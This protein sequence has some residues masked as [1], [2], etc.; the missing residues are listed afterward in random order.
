MFGL[1]SALFAVL[2]GFSTGAMAQG[3]EGP[4]PDTRITLTRDV[5]LPG[6]DLRSIFDTTLEACQA[7]CLTDSAC[8][9]FTFNSRSNSCFPKSAANDTEP[10]VGAISG[11]VIATDPAVLAQASTR[12]A[13]LSFV[14][15]QDIEK[16]V[17]LA[18][19]LGRTAIADTAGVEDL[20]QSAQ[21]KRAGGWRDLALADVAAAISLSDSP[22]LWAY[23]AEIALQ[24]AVEGTYSDRENF[25]IAQLA[26]VNAYLRST[27][28]QTRAAF[29]GGLASAFEQ[30]G[31]GRMMIP[32]LRLATDLS[33]REDLAAE[34]TRAIGQYGFRVI[35]TQV[36]SNA[37]EPRI[38]AVFSEA[39]RPAGTD[40]ARFVRTQANGLAISADGTQLCLNG[41][42]HGERYEFT[43]RAGLPGTSGEVLIKDVTLTQYVRD[44]DP[45][46]RF[47]GRA[48]VL[49]ATGSPSVPIVTVNTD[50]VNLTLR[51]V[52]ER[53]LVRAVQDQYFGR[54]LSPW[55]QDDFASSLAEEVWTGTGEVANT[56]N[57]E[58][59]T[60]LPLDQALGDLSAGIY[61][62]QASVPDSNPYDVASAS[63]WFVISDLGFSTLQGND[64]L[65]V[66]A[67]SLRDTTP[68][69]GV[70]VTLLSRSNRVL[71]T[72]VTDA[73]G[74]LNLQPGLLAGTG[75]AE[76][77]LVVL[78][79]GD[80]DISFMS[81]TDPA[82]DL[83]DRGVTGRAPPE[84]IDVFL[85]T[86]RGAYRAGETIYATALA[87]DPS[88]VA[89]TDVPLTAILRRPDGVEYARMRSDGAALGGH[90][91]DFD[92]LGG[93]PRGTWSVGVYADPDRPAL[94]R[95]T[96]LV[97]DFLPERFDFDLT[98]ANGAVTVQADYLFGAPAAELPVE[99]D[100]T[101]TGT[102]NIDAYPGYQFGAY[103]AEVP[104]GSAYF[105]D[106]DQTDA[107]GQAVIDA[108]LPDVD[109][110]GWPATVNITMR[111]R[112]GSGR[113]VE[114]R[115]S[116]AADTKGTKI[117]IKPLFDD[118]LPEGDE[119]RFEIVTLGQGDVPVARQVEWE[120]N[121][122]QTRYQWYQL[123][124]NWNWE[125]VTTRTRI[126]SGTATT[127]DGRMSVSE[128]VAWGEYELIVA[129]TGGNYTRS[130]VSFY[131]GWYGGGAAGDSPDRLEMSLDRDGYAI[132]D[133]AML[134]VVPR[135]A[136][137]A[138]ITVMDDH[139]I[140]RE[141]VQMAAGENRIPLQI[142]ADWGAGA[143]VGVTLFRG[144]DV[145]N[146][147]EPARAMGIAY[148]PISPA[149]R[150][151]D[152]TVATVGEVSPRAP[153]TATVTIANLPANEPAYVT[154]A[155]VDVGILNLTGFETPEP[156]A[157]FFGQRKLGLGIRDVYGRLI[158]TFGGAAGSIRSGG[159]AS[160]QMRLQSPPPTEDL[161]AYFSGPLPVGADGTV[162]ATFDI[163]AFN[164]TVRLMAMAWSVDG[165][166]HATTDVIIAD[167]VVMTASVPRFMAPGDET[168][169]LLDLQRT[170]ALGGD[171]AFAMTTSDGLTITNPLP[172]TVAL[173]QT[174]A[175]NLRIPLRAGE[176]GTQ[177]VNLSLTL[178][179]GT[180]LTK[181][182]TIPVMRNDP[183]TLRTNRFEVVSGA[184]FTLTQ[185]VFDGFAPGTARATLAFGPL[186][187]FDAPGLLQGL[188]R[189]PYGCTEQI[190]ARALP[191]LYFN[192]V[193]DAMG[194]GGADELGERLNTAVAQ[195][196]TN[197]A[198]NGSFGLWSA[199]TGDLWLD[200]YVTDFLGRA[201]ANGLTVP[202]LAYTQ[203]MDNLRNQ[204]NYAADFESGGDGIAYALMVLARDGRATIGDLRYYADVKADAFTTPLGAAQLGAALAF[205]G[206]QIRADYM[207]AQAS[208]LMS[209]RAER[210]DLNTWRADYGTNR[211]D[212]AAILALA[213][214]AGTTAVNTDD[215]IQ[216]TTSGGT[217]RTTQEAAWTLL[218]AHALIDHAA[219]QRISV[220]DVQIGGP[221]LAVLAQ[222]IAE[223]DMAIRND[224]GHEVL[225]TLTTYGVPDVAPSAGGTGYD[226]S[227]SYYTLDGVATDPA[228]VAAGTR[229]VTVIDV[230]PFATSEARLMVTD[231]L[232]AGFEIDN[233]N[234]LRGGD[235]RALDWLNTETNVENAEFRQD[236]FMAAIDWTS[237]RPFQLAYIV[238]ATVPGTYQH[239]AATVEDMYRPDQR[240]WTGAG[241]VMVR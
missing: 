229:L 17:K 150:Q 30:S 7:A 72:D 128:P 181:V 151:L 217:G 71:A 26:Y 152:V 6:G 185:D 205:Y 172:T 168:V 121:R 104:R 21:S 11:R 82:F 236:R 55:E 140:H 36:D 99:G 154:L 75:G 178:G 81:L 214:E 173:P 167:P 212:A 187:R 190:T 91:F 207:F 101:L 203:A 66:F 115:L 16:A 238:R 68:R 89:Q 136:G 138:L 25:G 1:R 107:T 77:A 83:S 31:Q 113:P 228:T 192:Q 200:A 24:E 37:A 149:D 156:D 241:R 184:S 221:T 155:A 103:D 222:G 118:V 39:L 86:D 96:V 65:H 197:Q 90:V 131:A 13:E 98:Y 62:L 164:G 126:A 3:L 70:E 59:T 84:P 20:L 116:Q 235:V 79:D 23:Y 88:V 160:A 58:T 204:V 12:R 193:A 206:E 33:P 213:S 27:N 110:N 196:L 125:P 108:P 40:Y 133:T 63:Q 95:S 8:R 57:A 194:L 67:R 19:T 199:E 18:R 220:N 52:A 14:S 9:A 182:L 239:P 211:R 186:A 141:T 142:D 28:D 162:S 53:N 47:P 227:R 102:R 38:C 34:L 48:Y 153:M 105:G 109:L 226:I 224:G 29:L 232:P 135:Y 223:T 146:E 122:V 45:V 43:L 231:R 159:D 174:G 169:M 165:V 137:T 51:R 106:G 225:M 134:R 143:Y 69:A 216:I 234:L 64:G 54:P 46:V 201:R 195:V 144:M 94:A 61:V 22:D 180:A 93:V 183:E 76:P 4:V 163:P 215:L 74:Y 42:Q 230:V 10:Y 114:R 32:A 188:D 97:E 129:E 237:D 120:L 15:D 219:V 158:D 179:D 166:G 50:R 233:P 198:S 202:E 92:L 56:L 240:A 49:P 2:I 60:R 148:A 78:R 5:D 171:V 170:T 161:V 132:G 119:A 145:Q 210:G 175:A 87:R 218:A 130:S 111:L 124:G 100:L 157:Y 80:K 176:V 44:R 189:Y 127:T 85:T 35:E 117:G 177:T 112:E 139:L 41:V 209:K 123:Y 208:R 147:L 191:L 73:E